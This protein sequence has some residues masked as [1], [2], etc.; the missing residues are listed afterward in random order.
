MLLLVLLV[1]LVKIVN[2]QNQL[3]SMNRC[4]GNCAFCSNNELSRCSGLEL[5]SCVKGYNGTNC[6]PRSI[7]SVINY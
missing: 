3:F 4:L 5:E 2:T 1:F 7:Y 6:L